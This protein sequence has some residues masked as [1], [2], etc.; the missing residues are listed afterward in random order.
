MTNIVSIRLANGTTHEWSVTS[1]SQE[2]ITLLPIVIDAL[3]RNNDSLVAEVTP[4]TVTDL[5]DIQQD[6]VT[7]NDV[8]EQLVTAL[9]A[10]KDISA[11]IEYGDNNSIGYFDEGEIA[12]SI[13]GGSAIPVFPSEMA[14]E[15]LE[16][17]D[18]W[19]LSEDIAFQV[20]NKSFT[21]SVSVRDIIDQYGDLDDICNEVFEDYADEWLV[22]DY[23]Y[24]PRGFVVHE[25]ERGLSVSDF[26]KSE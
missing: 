11:V 10:N 9:C 7:D 18:P 25:F 24:D 1:P 16:S 6:E 5:A 20:N 8:L 19:G 17:L 14:E 23:T 13:Q 2:Q 15:R 21:I 26:T 12:V 3:D 4:E 22:E